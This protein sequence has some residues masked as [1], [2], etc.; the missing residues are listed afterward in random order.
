MIL[1]KTYYALI[2]SAANFAVFLNRNPRG[3]LEKTCAN[4]GISIQRFGYV[5]THRNRRHSKS[6]NT[7]HKFTNESIIAN[8][9][10]R[11]TLLKLAVWPSQQG[12]S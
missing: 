1:G 10:Y 12:K 3:G 11:L 6:N 5:Y 4:E 7:E 9:Q 8:L 2:T